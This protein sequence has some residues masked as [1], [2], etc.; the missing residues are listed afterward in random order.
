[1]R[2]SFSI[3]RELS[4]KS[5]GVDSLKTCKQLKRNEDN[6]HALA[7]AGTM[8]SVYA[9]SILLSIVVVSHIATKINW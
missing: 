5:R 9:I 6:R 7:D 2:R 3:F 1:M 4:S 8:N